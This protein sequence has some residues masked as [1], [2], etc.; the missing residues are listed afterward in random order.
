MTPT[1]EARFA[2]AYA[3]ELQEWVASIL[4]GRRFTPSAWDG[5]VADVVAAACLQSLADED[6]VAVRIGERPTFYD[7]EPRATASV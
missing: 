2:A 6:A 5:H 7:T 3:R 4:A 1:S